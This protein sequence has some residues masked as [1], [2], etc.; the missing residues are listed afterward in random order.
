MGWSLILALILLAIVYAVIYL[1]FYGSHA[2]PIGHSPQVPSPG[3]SSSQIPVPE[4]NY[5]NSIVDAIKDF[6]KTLTDLFSAV[7]QLILA[8]T[9]AFVALRRLI[10]R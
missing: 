4:S 7:P 2:A 8:V 10:L 1:Y 6:V 3:A 5:I 9:A